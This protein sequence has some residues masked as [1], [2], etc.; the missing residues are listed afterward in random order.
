M[1]AAGLRYSLFSE[2]IVEN[3]RELIIILYRKKREV[4]K[5]KFARLILSSPDTER[6]IAALIDGIRAI[7]QWKLEEGQPYQITRQY[8]QWK[9]INSS[10]LLGKTGLIKK[11]KTIHVGSVG[12]SFINPPLNRFFLGPTQ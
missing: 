11:N 7:N 3:V 12:I 6:Q 5:T 4:L 1:L 8:T 9:S 10:N 2:V